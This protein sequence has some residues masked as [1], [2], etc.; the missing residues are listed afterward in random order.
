MDKKSVSFP[1]IGAA[2]ILFSAAT[3][4]LK[5]VIAKLIYAEGINVPTLLF[6]RF[7]ISLPLFWMFFLVR[8]G[9]KKENFSH[10]SRKSYLLCGATGSLYAISA[11]T[12]FIALSYIDASVERMILFTYPVFIILFT[13]LTNSVIFI[14]IS[15]YFFLFGSMGDFISVSS[16]GWYLLVFI[17]LFCTVIPFF[18]LYEGIRRIGSEKSALLSLGG[19]VVTI[20]ATYV[21]L[22]EQLTLNQLGGVLLIFIGIG[23]LRLTKVKMQ[24]PLRP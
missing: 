16:N 11:I 3:F 1:L 7:L 12:D 17:P 22:G 6:S 15:L 2:L 19:P 8:N 9:R 23:S 5:G 4:A 20:L 10:I 18:S 21:L 24:S 14:W 13:C